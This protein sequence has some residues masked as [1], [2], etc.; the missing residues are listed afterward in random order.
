MPRTQ[1]FNWH[2]KCTEGRGEVEDD[3]YTCYPSTSPTDED[4]ARIN[5]T[6]HY[7]R[8]VSIRVIADT[9]HR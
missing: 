1:L 7:D 5:K 8:H 3:K 9:D 6:F 2:E 4:I